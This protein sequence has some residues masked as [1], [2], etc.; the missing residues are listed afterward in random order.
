MNK[1][2]ITAVCVLALLLAAV[3][4]GASILHALTGN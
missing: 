3:T 2:I 4:F 1:Q